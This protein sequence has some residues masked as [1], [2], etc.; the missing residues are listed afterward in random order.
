MRGS[1]YVAVVCLVVCTCGRGDDVKYPITLAANVAKEFEGLRL[2]PY[3]DVAGFPTIGYG[4][5]LSSIKDDPLNKYKP[6]TETV[7]VA[8]L[9]H[10]LSEAQKEVRSLVTA[11]LTAGQEAA[12]IDFVFNE[13]A[14][15]LR[16]STLLHDINDGDTM[17]APAQFKRWVYADGGQEEGLVKRR[18]A[19]IKLWNGS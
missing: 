15:R 8:L 2:N 3:H 10:D 16:A 1:V 4:H 7:A 18:E 11:R 9:H 17:D 12:L 5:K 13:G 19:E 14:G 6:I